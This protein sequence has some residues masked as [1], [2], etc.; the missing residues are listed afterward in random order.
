M[1]QGVQHQQLQL[2][3]TAELRKN[4]K[5]FADSLG[6]VDGSNRDELRKWLQ[7]IDNIRAW[8][9]APDA[10]VIDLAGQKAHGPLRA[11]LLAAKGQLQ[12]PNRTW[13]NVKTGVVE[14]FL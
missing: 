7:D 8:T 9:N 6:P 10:L 3:A 4:L 11:A 2:Q 1:A 5:D 13:P 12:P 14:E